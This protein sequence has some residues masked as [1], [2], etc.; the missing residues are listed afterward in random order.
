MGPGVLGGE[1]TWWKRGSGRTEANLPWVPET[2]T[3]ILKSP[4]L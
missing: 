3:M 2:K 4:L 1:R